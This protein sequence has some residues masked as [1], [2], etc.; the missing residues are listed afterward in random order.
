MLKISDKL[1][2]CLASVSLIF[3][4]VQFLKVPSKDILAFLTAHPKIDTLYLDPKESL[5][6]PASQQLLIFL[7][8]TKTIH[9][10][11][12]KDLDLMKQPL[13]RLRLMK[14]VI[15]FKFMIDKTVI[16]EKDITLDGKTFDMIKYSSNPLYEGRL[17]FLNK[18]LT[19]IRSTKKR[20]LMHYIADDGY[21][22]DF[23]YL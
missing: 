20:L 14:K 5:A 15:S 16:S 4:T 8:N 13:L 1:P 11:I 10:V 6:D 17:E 19:S 22:I 3:L 12:W 2:S 18:F 9:K 21:K 23:K 7:M